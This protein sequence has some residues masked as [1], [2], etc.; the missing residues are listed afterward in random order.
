[1]QAPKKSPFGNV[2][3]VEYHSPH[4]PTVQ[5]H[6]LFPLALAWRIK[7]VRSRVLR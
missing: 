3:P 1:M 6:P 7:K 2:R 4:M 5:F